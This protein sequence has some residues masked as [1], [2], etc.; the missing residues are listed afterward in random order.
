MCRKSKAIK[1]TVTNFQI[2]QNKVEMRFYGK[3]AQDHEFSKVILLF[4][5]LTQ[6]TL[7]K[8]QK[9]RS[10]ETKMI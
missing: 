10:N 4:R 6:E 5:R 9:V 2:P 7:R 8:W 3:F 1:K